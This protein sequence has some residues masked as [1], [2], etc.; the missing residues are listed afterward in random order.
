MHSNKKKFPELD[1]NINFAF[2]KFPTQTS[3]FAISK[4]GKIIF[5][6]RVWEWIHGFESPELAV[7]DGVRQNPGWR[8]FYRVLCMQDILQKTPLLL[9]PHP[10]HHHPWLC[11]SLHSYVSFCK[12]YEIEVHFHHNRLRRWVCGCGWWF[13]SCASVCVRVFF[14]LHFIFVFVLTGEL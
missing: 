7:I 2:I 4:K 1:Y 8:R 10:I 3:P 5:N 13:D 6:M 14:P 11:L 12:C 9:P